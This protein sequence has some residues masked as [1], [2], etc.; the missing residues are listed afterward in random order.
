MD[1]LGR[2]IARETGAVYH[3]VCLN[4]W[5]YDVETATPVYA[6]RVHADHVQVFMARV[7]DEQKALREAA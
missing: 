7:E 5:G 4:D 1:P 2:T 6:I 3:P